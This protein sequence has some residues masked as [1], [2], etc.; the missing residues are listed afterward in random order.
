M[1]LYPPLN[2]GVGHRQYLFHRTLE[3]RPRFRAFDHFRGLHAYMVVQNSGPILNSLI[4]E[5][6]LDINAPECFL[7]LKA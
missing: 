2:L 1:C 5:A 3:T 6:S 7:T 4:L